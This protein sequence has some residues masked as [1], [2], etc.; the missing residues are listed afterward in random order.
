MSNIPSKLNTD[1]IQEISLELRRLNTERELAHERSG[2]LSAGKLG[3]PLLEQV[4]YVLGVPPKPAED[5]ALGLFRRGES[6]EESFLQLLKPDDTQVEVEYRGVIGYI[7]AVRNDMIYE[8]K[9]IK[10]SGVKYIDPSNDKKRRSPQGLVPEYTGP[11]YGHTLQLTLYLLGKQKEYG[12]L[13]YVSS[14]D[15]RI[16]PHIIDVK[17]MAGEVDRIID[18]F[19]AA[20][21]SKVLPRWEA[22]EAWQA[23][24]QYSSYP[25]WISLEPAQAM[26]KLKQQYPA[27]YTK[28]TGEKH[29][30]IY[31]T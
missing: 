20:I 31:I 7:D 22:R 17:T 26:Q 3:Q 15:M 5:Y 30:R 23:N 25:D 12:T 29:G 18:Q 1:L 4:L 9:S 13:V 21:Q 24:A 28:L 27:A 8:V 2:K 16:Y 10:N 19:E 11:K 6:V 14:D